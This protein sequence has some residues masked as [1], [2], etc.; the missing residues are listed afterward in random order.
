MATNFWLQLKKPIL[1]LAP[2][3]GVTDIAFRAICKQ[4]GADVVYTEFLPADGI[5][6]GAKKILE[7][8]K[9]TDDERPVICQIFG[10]DPAKFAI[11]A[12]KVEAMG[13]DGLDINFGCPARKVVS[14]G[15]GVAL[16]RT[17]QYARQL[18]EAAM[19]NT[20][21]PVSIKIRTSIRKERKE[22]LPGA[23]RYTALDLL[24]V[25]TDLP[26]AAIMVHG[27]S[28]ESGHSGEVDMDMIR[29]VKEAFQGIVLAN[30]GITTPEQAKVMLENTGTDGVGIARGSWGQPWIFQ[31]TREYL[32][33]G[34]VTP[35]AWDRVKAVILEHARLMYTT[36]GDWGLREFRKHL[37]HYIKGRPGAAIMRRQAVTVETLADVEALVAGL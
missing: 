9:R 23:D 30:G 14:S 13:F 24:A 25:I 36:K 10:R 31:Q 32:A 1:A 2:M 11:A 18:I 37:A 20:S 12:K 29:R 19:A 15:S 22:I 35:I 4:N 17:P 26:V 27:R 8:M 6:Y 28:F 34:Q 33:T 3:E 21:L 16:L 7:K 5:A